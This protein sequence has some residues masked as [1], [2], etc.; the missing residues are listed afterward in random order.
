MSDDR[1]EEQVARGDASSR[2]ALMHPIGG[3]Q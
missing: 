2:S 1:S 3:H